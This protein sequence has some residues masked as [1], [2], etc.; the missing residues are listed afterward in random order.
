[1]TKTSNSTANVK[2][3][4]APDLG[5]ALSKLTRVKSLNELVFMSGESLIMT[6][7]SAANAITAG[8]D[9]INEL[10]IEIQE[11][12]EGAWKGGAA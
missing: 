1:M 11:I 9:V 10:L 3:P 5:E 7:P 2:V 12:V 6:L 4:D 8:C